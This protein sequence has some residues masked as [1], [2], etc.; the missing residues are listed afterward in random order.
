MYTGPAMKMYLS[1]DEVL[2]KLFYSIV[3]T[4]VQL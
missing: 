3:K 2:Y 4:D 1:N